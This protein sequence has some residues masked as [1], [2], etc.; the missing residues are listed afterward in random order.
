MLE[1]VPTLLTYML[2]HWI[3]ESPRLSPGYGFQ[4][5]RP[6]LEFYGRL[7]TVDGL[8]QSTSGIHLCDKAKANRPFIQVNQ[9]L[10]KVLIDGDLNDAAAAMAKNAKGEEQHL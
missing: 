3:L 8:L 4:F 6:H 1:R 5:D 7:K 2:I 9:L 10:G